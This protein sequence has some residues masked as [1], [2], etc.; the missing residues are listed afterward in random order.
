MKLG[1]VND[2]GLGK[3]AE[4]KDWKELPSLHP[5]D[6]NKPRKERRRVCMKCYTAI[7]RIIEPLSFASKSISSHKSMA[8]EGD[9]NILD[10]KELHKWQIFNCPYCH[11]PIHYKFTIE[12]IIPRE[13]GGKNI[14]SNLLLVCKTCN[15][16]KQDFELQYWIELKQYRIRPKILTKI[17]GAYDEHGYEFNASCSHCLGSINTAI[18]TSNPNTTNT[19]CIKTSC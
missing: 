8:K 7:L 13:R 11:E 3:C 19:S 4:C 2:L 9:Y 6:K 10:I 14:L 12:H 1:E 16:S 17:K 5:K 18:C 15:S